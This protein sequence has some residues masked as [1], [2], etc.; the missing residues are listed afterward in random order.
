MFEVS[1]YKAKMQ[2]TTKKLIKKQLIKSKKEKESLPKL[3]ERGEGKERK[4]ILE[5]SNTRRVKQD[6]RSDNITI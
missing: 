5:C 4:K 2:I 3:R 6:K 1:T